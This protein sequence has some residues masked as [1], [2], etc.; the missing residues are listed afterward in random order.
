[1]IGRSRPS[2]SYV[3]NNPNNSFVS[4][5]VIATVWRT[6]R[7]YADYLEHYQFCTALLNYLVIKLLV[8]M[9]NE[10]SNDFLQSGKSL[11]LSLLHMDLAATDHL[12]NLVL[13]IKRITRKIP[14]YLLRL[15]PLAGEP[16]DITPPI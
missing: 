4:V 16:S 14:L 7:P 3:A 13:V 10:S 6:V 12:A 9:C 2:L 1:M 5:T 11:E 8:K 15:S